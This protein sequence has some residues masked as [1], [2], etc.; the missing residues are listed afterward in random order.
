MMEAETAVINRLRPCIP[1][2]TMRGAARIVAD[3]TEPSP[4][5]VKAAVNGK[6]T[7]RTRSSIFQSVF[8]LMYVL[9]MRSDA[10]LVSSDCVV[11]RGLFSLAEFYRQIP[12]ECAEL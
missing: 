10:P 5:I 9:C 4:D 3:G 12:R 7:Q 8:C 1:D 11:D 6:S 2:M